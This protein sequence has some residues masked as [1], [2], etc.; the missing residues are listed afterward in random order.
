M[1]S[2]RAHVAHDQRRRHAPRICAALVGELHAARSRGT[3][4]LP[5]LESRRPERERKSQRRNNLRA[6]LVLRLFLAAAGRARSSRTRSPRRAPGSARTDTHAVCVHGE[7]TA[8]AKTLGRSST[9]N[10]EGIEGLILYNKESN[11]DRPIEWLWHTAPHAA[12][13]YFYY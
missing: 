5:A 8:D 13:S 7:A 9:G 3:P 10:R 11:C 6:L 12:L 2:R 4:T 1:P